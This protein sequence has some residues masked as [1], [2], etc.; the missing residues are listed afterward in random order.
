MSGSSKGR[1]PHTIAYLCEACGGSVASE[2]RAELRAAGNAPNCARGAQADAERP[3]VDALAEVAVA[4]E[5]LGRRVVRRAA[6]HLEHLVRRAEDRAEPKV[7][8][9]DVA[10]GV[11]EHVLGLEVAVDHVGAVARVDRRHELRE[12]L[13]RLGLLEAAVLHDVLEELAARH[14]L[15]DQVDRVDRLD[16]LEQVEHLRVLHAVQDGDLVHQPRPR[17][18]VDDLVLLQDLHRHRLAR[19]ALDREHHLA[20]RAVADRLEQR[21]VAHGL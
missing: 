21:V 2:E 7:D 15:G 12:E 17:V 4:E 10:V 6:R 11:E 9:L 16:H 19:V 3:H 13:H 14:V 5:H 18:L 1:Q 8:E 20:E